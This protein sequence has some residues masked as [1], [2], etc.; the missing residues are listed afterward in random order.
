MRILPRR[1]RALL[2]TLAVLIGLIIFFSIFTNFWTELLWYRSVGYA[3][4]FRTRLVTRLLLFLVFGLIMGG[5]VGGTV[6]AAYRLRPSFRGMSAEQ[7][8]LD[9]YRMAI[10]PFR[11]LIVVGIALMHMR[12]VLAV[13]VVRQRMALA[14]FL[15][16][17][18]ALVLH[19]PVST[20]FQ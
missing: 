5:A 13:D 12:Q 8:S 16:R 19:W 18:I 2:P 14:R 20:R 11:R 1:P 10:D 7:Q 17:L 6:Y 4:V 3:G 15:V 9:R